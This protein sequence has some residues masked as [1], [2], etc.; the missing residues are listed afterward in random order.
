M[1]F[2]MGVGVEFDTTNSRGTVNSVPADAL[3]DENSDPI[4]DEN[5]SIIT[6]T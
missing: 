1:K 4:T 6:E 5:N 3:L 2:G